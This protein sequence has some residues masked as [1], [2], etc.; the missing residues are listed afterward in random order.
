MEEPDFNPIRKL[1]MIWAICISV[2]IIGLAIYSIYSELNKSKSS[3]E[4]EKPNYNITIEYK[5]GSIDT[6]KAIN[7]TER[8][9]GEY[10][11]RLAE[12]DDAMFLDEEDYKS[13]KI[14]KID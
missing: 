1:I 14:E 7:Y 10:A 6:Y 9:K 5:N 4:S 3:V 8:R 2:L 11:I 12:D 13:I